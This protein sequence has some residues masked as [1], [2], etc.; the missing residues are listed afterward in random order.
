[1][2][3]ARWATSRRSEV[4]VEFAALAFLALLFITF[5]FGCGVSVGR[6]LGYEQHEREVSRRE[7]ESLDKC[8]AAWDREIRQRG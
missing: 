1:M 2:R 7:L 3:G 5:V 6:N 4:S 8:L